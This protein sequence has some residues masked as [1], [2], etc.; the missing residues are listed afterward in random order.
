MPF[1]NKD[2]IEVVNKEQ[3]KIYFKNAY[4]FKWSFNRNSFNLKLWLSDDPPMNHVQIDEE[5]YNDGTYGDYHRNMSCNFEVIDAM[6]KTEK[7]AV[8]IALDKFFKD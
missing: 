8:K 3:A 7:T 5:S 2:G 1:R 6:T 4:F